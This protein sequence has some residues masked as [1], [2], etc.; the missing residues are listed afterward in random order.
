MS[1]I[2][3]TEYAFIKLFFNQREIISLL[4]AFQK[5]MFYYIICRHVRRDR[6]SDG[7]SQRWNECFTTHAPLEGR[8]PICDITAFRGACPA[9]RFATCLNVGMN[10]EA[11]LSDEARDEKYS[12]EKRIKRQ[13]EQLERNN[14][15]IMMTVIKKASVAM[16]F[17]TFSSL[18]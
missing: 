3:H 4:P 16:I 14:A 10:T 12:A 11:V 9:C 8:E 6:K 13:Q 1:S 17:L 18:V 15:D 7:S 5:N 2:T